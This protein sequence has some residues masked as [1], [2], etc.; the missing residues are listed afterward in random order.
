MNLSPHFTLEEATDS[1][2]AARRGIN[3]QPSSAQIENMQS[4]AEGMELVRDLLGLPVRVNSWFRCPELNIAIGGSAK[5]AHMDG[6]A[7]DFTCAGYGTPLS[8][9]R[10]I[11]SSDIRFDKLI[12]EGTWVHISFHPD[13]RGSILTAHFLAGHAATYT[14]GL[15]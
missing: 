10:A 1:G 12:F 5:S 8:I 3:N 11:Q 6:W 2:T 14:E 15:V 4:A 9:C 13:L 7:I